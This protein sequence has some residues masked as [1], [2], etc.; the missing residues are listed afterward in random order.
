[1]SAYIV[2]DI[3]I[4][5]VLAFLAFD[6]NAEW[7]K[8]RLDDAGLGHDMPALG[9][10]MF[11]LNVEAVRQRYDDDNIE[12][13]RSLDY[14]Y[15]A[16]LP[17]AIHQALKSLHCWHYQCTEGNVLTSALYRLMGD[18]AHDLAGRIVS[19]LPEYRQAE[20]G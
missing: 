6:R 3:T 12:G 17:P 19:E 13:F 10:A 16:E 15:R 11:A 7:L 9:A 14:E 5:R 20:W 2:D 18:Y 1:M 4:N 8:L